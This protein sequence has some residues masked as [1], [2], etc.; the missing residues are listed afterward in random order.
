[1]NNNESLNQKKNVIKEKL[2]QQLGIVFLSRF[3][4]FDNDYK[5]IK[6]NIKYEGS[7]GSNESEENQGSGSNDELI[8]GLKKMLPNIAYDFDNNEINVLNENVKNIIINNQNIEDKISIDDNLN[9]DTTDIKIIFW[10]SY[11]YINNN[12]EEV[13][14]VS[15]F[16]IKNNKLFLKEINKKTYESIKNKKKCEINGEISQDILYNFFKRFMDIDYIIKNNNS[17]ESEE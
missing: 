16:Y 2:S 11:I 12:N 1:M 6:P 14:Y 4:E 7:E 15:L 13:D 10:Y 8:N 9:I 3:K 5:E 17:K